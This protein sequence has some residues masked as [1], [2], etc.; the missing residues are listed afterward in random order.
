[1][2]CAISGL[3]V[4]RAAI[5]P[6]N[7]CCCRV[8]IDAS[9]VN[10]SSPTQNQDLVN[11]PAAIV[12]MDTIGV[13]DYSAAN[14][15][16]CENVGNTSLTHTREVEDSDPATTVAPVP[17][18]GRGLDVDAKASD[19]VDDRATTKIHLLANSDQATDATVLG[20]EATSDEK[21]LSWT[22]DTKGGTYEGSSE[23]Y[24]V[25]WIKDKKNWASYTFKNNSGIAKG[26]RHEQIAE[27]LNQL[28]RDN[29]GGLERNRTGNSVGRKITR[30][31][32]AVRKQHN[33][34]CECRKNNSGRK[35]PE[36]LAKGCRF[37]SDLYPIMYP[38]G[39]NGE[40]NVVV[41]DDSDNLEDASTNMVQEQLEIKESQGKTDDLVEETKR[42]NMAMGKMK[43]EEI[44]MKQ[45]T[46]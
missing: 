24:L 28:G 33:T 39:V 18:P 32:E 36:I 6:Y 43:Q 17:T 38:L 25:N 1:M 21:I 19:L 31:K 20:T 40:A 13:N 5:R 23:D 11:I 2:S 7:I 34:L 37:Y 14:Q 30:M 44:K 16:D 15:E 45:E 26:T 41:I 46:V 42:H 3:C 27:T 8:G 22:N 35:I 29:H 4:I 10:D 12:A 9:G